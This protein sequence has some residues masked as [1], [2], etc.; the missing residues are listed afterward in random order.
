M[1]RFLPSKIFAFTIKTSILAFNL[2]LTFCFQSVLFLYPKTVFTENSV[3]LFQLPHVYKENN[4]ANYRIV[5]KIELGNQLFNTE[6]CFM[7]D[8]IILATYIIIQIAHF[9][10]FSYALLCM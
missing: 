8:K 1:F 3:I 4:R 7:K 10:V 9:Y 5:I 2:V 6:F